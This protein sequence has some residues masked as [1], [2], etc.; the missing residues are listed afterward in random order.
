MK[1]LLVG[2]AAAALTVSLSAPPAE[3]Q[4]STYLDKDGGVGTAIRSITVN[5]TAKSLRVT[6]KH[7][8]LLYGDTVWIDSRPGDAGPEYRVMFLANSDSISLER[9]ESFKTKS[10]AAWSCAGAEVRSDNFAPGAN[11]WI[12]IPRKCLKGPGKVRIQTESWSKHNVRDRAPNRGTYWPG[13]WFTPW[14]MAG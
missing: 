3:A 6:M 14:V 2:A 12:D 4:T 10:G 9:V 8:K 1:K 7:K 13:R 5:N 11:S